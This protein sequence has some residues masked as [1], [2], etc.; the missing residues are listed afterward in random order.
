MSSQEIPIMTESIDTT[1]TG[2]SSEAAKQRLQQYGPNALE[3]KKV[4]G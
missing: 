4:S 2:L 3:E 1:M